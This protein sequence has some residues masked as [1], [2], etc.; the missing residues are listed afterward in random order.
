M[1]LTAEG[2]LNYSG[3][4]TGGGGSPGAGQ[5]IVIH[6]GSP[7]GTIYTDVQT[8]INAAAAGDTVEIGAGTYTENV[9]V[10]TNNLTIENAPGAKVTI[11]GTGGYGG[12][13]TIA[14]GIFGVTIKSSDG[15]PANFVVEGSQT[16]GQTAALYIAGDNGAI[17]INGITTVAAASGDAGL[18]SVL[19]GGGLGNV[20]FANNVFAGNAQQLVYVNGA[21]DLGPSAQNGNVNFVGNTFSGSAG[22]LLG[23]SAPGEVI[24]NKFSGASQVAVG[25]NESG[26]NVSGNTF[27]PANTPI[28][29]QG[30]FFGDG[31]Y[32]PKTI[33]ANNS[34]PQQG[35]IYIIRNGVQQDGVYTNIQ[36]AID[37]AFSGDTV[38]VGNGTYNQNV[39]L[40]DGVNVQG[41]SQA[42]VI[43][44]GTMST[45]ANFDNTTVSNLTVND[46]S[47]TAML[48]DMT[49]TQEITD[50][51]FNNVTFNLNS[52]SSATVLIGNG[53]VAGSMALNDADGDGAGL[54]FANVT[55]NS[56][57]NNFANSTAFAFTLFHSVN[58]AQMLLNNVSLNGTAS[59]T[60][61]GLGAQW[62]MSPNSGETAN[63]TIENSSTSGGGNFYVSGMA[64][65]TI[66]NNTFNGQ[67]LALNGVTNGTVTGNTFENISNTYTANGTQHRGLV[68]EN[69]WGATGDSNIQ[70]E[71]NTFQNITATDGAIAFQRWTDSNGNLIPATIAQL[72]DIDVQG[73]TF[74]GVNTPVYLN[75][76]S[77]NSSTVIPVDFNGSQLIVGT[78][79]HDTINDTSTGPMTIFGGGGNDT[80]NGGSG[81]TTYYASAG[82]TITDTGGTDEVRTTGSFTLPANVENL[83]LLNGDSSTQTFNNMP[84]GPITNGE[85]G[86]E[87]LTPGEDEGIVVGPNGSNEFKMSSDPG[88]TA[89][90]GPYS[91]GLSVAAGEP[92]AGAQF[93]G[94][95]ISYNFQAVDPT[96][97]G[98]RLE[99]DFG[100]ASGTDRNNFLVIESVPGQGLRIAV[101]EPD[102]SGNFSGDGTDPEPNDWRQLVSDVDPI[103]Q[104][105]LTMQLTYVNG[106]N[107]DVINI[108]LDGKFIGSTTTFENYR[109][110]LTGVADHDANAAANL[111]DRIFFRPSPNGAPQDGPGGQNQG[112]YFD[113]ITNSVYNN[114]NGTGNSLNNVITGNDGNN[115]LTGGGGNDTLIGGAGFDTANYLGTLTATAGSSTPVQMGRTKEPIR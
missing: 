12:A 31:S 99:V 89:F 19:T 91:P 9:L 49:A 75:P 106:P 67:G 66:T 61:S 102:P 63:V 2:A 6:N 16:T 100:N 35:E 54:T 5:I 22:T 112:F 34:F 17:K 87:V 29:T 85:N 42:G 56:N 69:A 10:P 114:S 41:Q 30:Y 13:L 55:M 72:N 76:G 3:L 43:I 47:S 40:K 113:N 78:A 20:L 70:V 18:N 60:N 80:I 77:F 105:T 93:S 101:S 46:N 96:P 68:I 39:A 86:W 104:H 57:D 74:T 95:T 52:S 109:D 62:N 92:N 53:Q 107:N 23:M 90:G 15:V 111:T 81:N 88:N 59:G 115:I 1:P 48:L 25:L 8:A 24:N 97:D 36:D 38:F 33:E 79:G 82:D 108:Y 44:N 11:I 28:P 32:D 65:A 71:N 83:T 58:G 103:V 51:A 94:E 64:S 73:N 14:S 4:L 110:A 84:L 26:V 27:S 7:T 21:E 37:N 50:S 45:P 98:S